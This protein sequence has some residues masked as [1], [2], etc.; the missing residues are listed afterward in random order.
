MDY[1]AVRQKSN[2]G[3]A[4]N[5]R[6]GNRIA[7]KLE[8]RADSVLTHGHF[9][10]NDPLLDFCAEFFRQQRTDLPRG[11]RWHDFMLCRRFDNCN[12]QSERSRHARHC[13]GVCSFERLN[14]N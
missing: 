6:S 14:G 7:D 11:S 1:F 3:G 5:D 4:W 12:E 13:S 9:V 2:R 8:S 10:L